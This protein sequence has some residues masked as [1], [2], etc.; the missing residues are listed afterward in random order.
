M[1]RKV[2][3]SAVLA[4]LMLIT[5]FLAG[6]AKQP[7]GQTK[8]TTNT[9]EPTEKQPKLQKVVVAEATR[10]EYWLPVYLAHQL[11]YFKE[12][13]LEAEFVTYKDG[14]LALL[15]LVSGDAQFCIIGFEPVLR[16]YEQ[17]KKTKVILTTTYNQPYM[18]ATRK[19]INK[20]SDLK[21]KVIFAGMPSSAPYA[22]ARAVL[23]TAG[24]D[25]DKDVTFANLEYGAEIAA[26]SKG[27][28]DGTYVRASRYPEF[29]AIGANILVDATD[30]PQHKKIFGS[31]RYEA[32]TVQVTDDFI[33]TNPETVQ[34]F[35]NAVVKAMKWQFDHSDEEV[36]AKIA[37]LFPGRKIDARLINTVKRSLSPDG[38]FTKEGYATVERFC[39]DV[40]LITKPVP[41]EEVIDQSFIKKAHETLGK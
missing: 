21:G 14:P 36:A 15:G 25:P 6:C 7:A 23:K 38:Y 3:L 30:P 22:F 12:E 8:A 40:G 10:G 5:P 18:F 2:L 29:T 35:V 24:L 31:E 33:K 26:L 34:K 32:M 11:G 1:R 4:A 41:F 17:G 28:I 27:E 9:G 37:P 16:A 19:G 20:I 39:K 13:G